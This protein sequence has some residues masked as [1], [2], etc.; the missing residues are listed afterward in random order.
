MNVEIGTEAAQFLFWKY[1]FRFFEIVSLQC[2]FQ[3][4]PNTA[5]VFDAQVYGEYAK[6]SHAGVYGKSIF[7]YME[8]TPIDINFGL[9]RRILGQNQKIF[10]P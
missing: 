4:N 6:S 7:P 2:G 10:C 9:P 5:K 1:L 8:Y 3:R